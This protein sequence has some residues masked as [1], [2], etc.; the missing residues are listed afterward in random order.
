[1]VP[2]STFQAGLRNLTIRMMPYVPA[3]AG[4]MEQIM[5]PIREA[6]NGIEL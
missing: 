4:V 2:S 3:K 5:K 1:M 6:A